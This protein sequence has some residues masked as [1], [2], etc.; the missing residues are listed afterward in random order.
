V[1]S[2]DR[3]SQLFEPSARCGRIGDRLRKETRNQINGREKCQADSNLPKVHV[4]GRSSTVV[5]N[6]GGTSFLLLVSDSDPLAQSR[7][8]LRLQSGDSSPVMELF[9]ILAGAQFWRVFSIQLIPF[10]MSNSLHSY[11]SVPLSS[12]VSTFRYG[13]TFLV[14]ANLGIFAICVDFPHSCGSL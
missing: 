7:V 3:E 12:I 11:E 13:S 4:C 6:L 5:G 9:A 14:F 1:N 2:P 10:M 8:K